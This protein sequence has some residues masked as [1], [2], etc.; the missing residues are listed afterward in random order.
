[1]GR[2]WEVREVMG[3]HGRS[4]GV[5]GGHGRS[6]RSWEVMGG[7][8]RSWEVMGYR[9]WESSEACISAACSVAS[10]QKAKRT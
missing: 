9:T 7:H 1:M 8:G 4:W 10:R 3:G 5:M 2:S 6:W